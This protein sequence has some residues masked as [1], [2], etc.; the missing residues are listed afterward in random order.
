[1]RL[2]YDCVRD[3]LLKLEK[4][5]TCE[6]SNGAISLE[7]ISIDKLYQA[8]SDDYSIEDIFYSAYN[9]KQAEFLEANFLMGD[10]CIV[11]GVIF[12]ITYSGH[13]F[14]QQIRPKTVWDKSKSVF[15]NIGT[16]SVDIIK[17]VTNTILTDTIKHYIRLPDSSNST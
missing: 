5:L 3:V 9:L 10:G 1:M 15:K 11:D 13:Q 7:S 16:I 6:Y 4:I 14:L 8:L 12:N 17:S 2:N